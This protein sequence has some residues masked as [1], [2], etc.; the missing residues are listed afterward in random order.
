MPLHLH[1]VK[2]WPK[3]SH[4]W[5][6][7]LE[8]GTR[9]RAVLGACRHSLITHLHHSHYFCLERPVIEAFQI[10]LFL[11]PHFTPSPSSTAHTCDEVKIRYWGYPQLA[12][13]PKAQRPP[14]S[15]PIAPCLSPSPKAETWLT[16][17]GEPFWTKAMRRFCFNMWVQN[18]KGRGNF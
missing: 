13:D 2:G 11:I 10:Y 12:N 16:M 9:T 15:S 5:R 4:K 6:G 7:G 8:H 1:L 3:G 17:P 14:V 18:W